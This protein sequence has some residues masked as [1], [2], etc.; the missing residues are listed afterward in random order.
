MI[1]IPR[2]ILRTY[3]SLVRRAGLHKSRSVPESFL[4]I[5]ADSDGCRIRVASSEI[6]IEH[7]LVGGNKPGI[8]ITKIVDERF[9][10][11]WLHEGDALR[12]ER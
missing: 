3:R 4:A 2:P 7:R 11:F 8:A 1:S 12:Y 10:E 6:A 9:S 5:V